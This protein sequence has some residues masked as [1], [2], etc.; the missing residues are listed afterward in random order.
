MDF[1]DKTVLVVG[2]ARS[3]LAAAKVLKSLGARVIAND[4]KD[5]SQLADVYIELDSL[6]V[7]WALVT[8]PDE[9]LSSADLIV[10]SPGISIDSQFVLKAREMGIEVISE[11]E[12]AYRLCKA[13]IVAITGTNG[14]TTTTALVGEIFKASNRKTHVVGNIGIPFIGIASKTHESQVVVAEISSFQLEAMPTFHP[15]AAAI[16]NVSEDHLDR[17]KTMENYISL[18]AGILKN[19]GQSDWVILNADDNISSSLARE[20]KGQVLLFSSA[21]RLRKGAWVEDDWII[22]DLGQGREKVCKTKDVFIPGPHNLQNAL[23]A[24][25][26][27]RAMGVPVDIIGQV[28]RVFPGVEHRIE[29][30]DT[31][32]GI[33]FYNDSKGTNIDAALKAIESMTSP[34]VLIAGGYDKASEFDPLIDGFGGI[35]S[36]LVV[37]GQTSDK[38]IK[39]AKDKA[40]QNVYKVDSLEEGVK[41]AF[42]LALPDGNV[43]L[44][45]ACASWD[46]F[47]DF[48]ERGRVFK[49]AVKVLKEEQK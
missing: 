9:Y 43:L 7:E 3:G 49:E 39:A 35:V 44:S 31:I 45:P 41:K 37:L 13:P 20:T 2:L 6:G 42:S 8:K 36:H 10:I 28:L 33:T 32:D 34:T 26:I 5:R 1:R 12:L 18:K 29:L 4:I 25:L 15:R 46:M 40:F 11:V 17:H 24:A 48:E 23:A 27:T 38:I 14:K 30:V 22:V 16:L 21:Q 47:K 19:S